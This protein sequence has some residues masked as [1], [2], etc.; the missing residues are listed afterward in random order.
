MNIQEYVAE[1]V[2]EHIKLRDVEMAGLK[3]EMEEMRAAL[4]NKDLIKCDWCHEWRNYHWTC[5]FCDKKSCTNCHK[6]EPY[7]SWNLSGCTACVECEAA[8]CTNCR[9]TK[10]KCREVQ[11]PMCW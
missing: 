3:A 9:Q 10:E 1:R 6:V 8:Y 7:Q 5:E 2:I 4:E 11:L